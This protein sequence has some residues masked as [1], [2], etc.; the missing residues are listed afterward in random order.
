[1]PAEDPDRRSPLSGYLRY[2][3]L[4][5]QLAVSVAL[6]TLGGVWLD[7]RLGTG[8]LFTLLGLALGFGGGFYAM[9]RDLYARDR[10]PSDS[11]SE[12]G[13]DGDTRG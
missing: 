6:F 5:V 8:V 3:Y 1:L 2:S 12:E 11:Q 4:G 9:Y 10:R 13:R 7:R